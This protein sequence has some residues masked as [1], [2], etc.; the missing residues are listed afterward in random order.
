MSISSTLREVIRNMVKN[1]YDLQ[2]L[3]IAAGNRQQRVNSVIHLDKKSQAFFK[4]QMEHLDSLEKEAEVEVFACVKTHPLWNAFMKD[5]KGLGPR[6]AGVI[7]SEFDIHRATTV[8]K[9]W[10]VAGLGKERQWS[11]V[12]RER[13]ALL[14][15]VK[16]PALTPKGKQ[17]K[18]RGELRWKN[19]KR[20]KKDAQG[21][22]EWGKWSAW[23]KP[24]VKDS[25]GKLKDIDVWATS[26]NSAK[27]VI[28]KPKDTVIEREFQS[29]ELVSDRFESQ[30]K[31]VGQYPSFNVW[32]RAKIIG[33]L[34]DS[35][36]KQRTPKYRELYENYKE[37]CNQQGVGKDQR[38]KSVG[39]V[40]NAARRFIAK[41]FL[42]D[43]YNA[44]RTLEKL[45]VRAPYQEEYLGHKHEEEAVAT[46]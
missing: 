18:S 28:P 3:R 37:R 15:T 1:M 45:P 20:V 6:M 4:R 34:A 31:H 19:E 13:K 25:K 29:V 27:G 14:E 12:F 7:L 9:L 35:F 8:S 33:V 38:W 46:K 41:R 44:W 30:K 10:A 11:V 26:A 43:L 16:V 17:S 21:N 23:H 42:A 40:D 2:N 39:H 5:I 32:L 36:V 24:T 22:T